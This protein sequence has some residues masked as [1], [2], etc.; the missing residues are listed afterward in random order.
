MQALITLLL[1]RSRTILMLFVLLLSLG[2]LSYIT[3]PKEAAPDVPIP[4]VHVSVHY[5]GIS[6]EDSERLLVLPLEKE[7]RGIAGIKEITST[8]SQSHASITLEFIAGLDISQVMADVRDKV[9]QAKSKLPDGSDEPVIKQIT[10][11]SMEPVIT[12]I[13]SGDMPERA[14]IQI[15][16]QIR[17]VLEGRKEILEVSMG[18]DR[19]DVIDVIIDP[20]KLESYGLVPADVVN[21]VSSNNKLVAA[22]NIDNGNGRFSVKVPA[23]YKSPADILAQPV[24]VNGDTVITFADVA[25]V[26]STF[27]EGGSYASM[28]GV[29]S[30]S[31]EVKK[32]PGENI[33]ETIEVTKA[34]IAKAQTLAPEN[35]RLT[36][37]KTSRKM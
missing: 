5:E 24:K 28:N 1:S 16:R 14:L 18:G 20:L 30:V 3:I 13:L 32:R 7:L 29:P 19:E 15:A 37:P 33:I 2:T 4:V 21:L 17:D 34:I 35:L 6:P 12:V 27:K 26:R 11:A 10:I 8:A 25:T 36:T 23:V 22:G 31:L 9:N